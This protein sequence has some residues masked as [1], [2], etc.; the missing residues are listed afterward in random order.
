MRRNSAPCF[1]DNEGNSL[2]YKRIDLFDRKASGK[3]NGA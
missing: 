2:D 3:I 1:I